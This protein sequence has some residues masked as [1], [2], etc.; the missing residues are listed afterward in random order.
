MKKFTFLAVAL[1]NLKRK[2]F[3]SG[4]LISAIAILVSLLIFA[5]SFSISVGSSL[6]KSSDRLGADLIIVPVGARGFAE[7]FLLE[8]KHTAFYMPK[9][10]IKRVAAIEGI[11][12]LTH[13]TY[14]SSISGL[15]CDILPTRIIA[16][17]PENDFIIK[18]WLQGSLG[19]PLQR[20]EAI[21]GF[22][23]NEN[24]GLGLLA[25]ETTI[26]NNKF[27]I[28]GVLE[29]TGTGLDNALFMTEENLAAIIESGKSPLKKGEI[30]IIFAK[31][32]K[33]A[34][35]DYVG[36]V[37]EGSIVDVDVVA[38]SNMGEKFLNVLADIN[39]IF[40]IS[41]TLSSLLTIFLVWAIFSAIAN[42]RAKEIGIMRAIGAKESHITKLFFLEVLTLGII[43]SLIG[44]AAGTL[45]AFWLVHTF[46][47]IKTISAQ[48]NLVHQLVIAV[49]GLIL[50][51][52][53]CVGGALLPIN[54]IKK[55]EPLLV[56]KEE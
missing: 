11:E 51:S 24:L 49:A 46:T 17:D 41:I 10:M 4:I 6:K 1:K 33:G 42:E 43:G 30:S 8:S 25:V 2:P 38:R 36:R 31:V 7:E 18:P 52:G 29:Q 28:V 15:C 53:I 34:D 16:F 23:T 55:M 45:L 26:F 3:R 12:T 56:I 5:I 48:L 37:V 39:K 20:G 27:K 50:G 21:A 13:Q 35:P 44:V 32:K 14:L 40:L 19:R 22:G 9:E 47:L 54:R